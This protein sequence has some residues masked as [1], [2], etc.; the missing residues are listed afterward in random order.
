[1]DSL[2][3]WPW[4]RNLNSSSVFGR[5]SQGSMVGGQRRQLGER[6]E[7]S[8]GCIN[9][10]VTSLGTWNASSWWI[11][12]RFCGTH[13]RAVALNGMG[14]VIFTSTPDL[15]HSWHFWSGLCT[16]E[17]A[18]AVRESLGEGPR[19]LWEEAIWT[20]SAEGDWEGDG[21]HHSQR[22]KTGVQTWTWALILS[23]SG[24]FIPSSS[25]VL[26]V[27]ICKVLFC[28]ESARISP[29][30]D[31]VWLGTKASL[32][33]AQVA[34][35]CSQ[36]SSHCSG[37]HTSVQSWGRAVSDCAS[38]LISACLTAAW[39]TFCCNCGAYITWYSDYF[40]QSDLTCSR[41]HVRSPAP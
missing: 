22:F 11:P 14:A 9:E 7:S 41:A 31:E 19:W 13:F 39:F 3:S 1:M 32:F 37:L 6:T 16:E 5:G 4:D 34:F 40:V 15:M 26:S 8:T 30:R 33:R 38:Q 35:V 24:K 23:L 18:F 17:H 29:S 12:L 20:L 21:Q 10:Q 2:R 27:P 25:L 28:S 36:A